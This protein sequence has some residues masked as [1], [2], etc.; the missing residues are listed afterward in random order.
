MKQSDTK[1]LVVALM[2]A[3][4]SSFTTLATAVA[5]PARLGPQDRST[6]RPPPQPNPC[7]NASTEPQLFAAEVV[8]PQALEPGGIA[9]FGWNPEYG[10]LNRGGIQYV[11]ANFVYVNLTTDKCTYVRSVNFGS[12]VLTPTDS[13]GFWYSLTNPPQPS[14]PTRLTHGVTVNFPYQQD[15]ASDMVSIVVGRTGGFGSVESRFPVVR[16][17][18]VEARDVL[19]SIGISRAELF[20][21]F[22]KALFAK[23]GPTNSTVIYD[24]DG[25]DWRIYGYDPRSLAVDITTAGVSFQFKFKLDIPFWCDP[26]VRAY[27]TFRLN[28]DLSGISVD[29]VH[30]AKGSATWPL[31]CEALQLPLIVPAIVGAVIGD[32]AESETSSSVRSDVEKAV[33]DAVPG[34]GNAT[35][36]LRGSA[37]VRDELLVNLSM[38]VPSVMIRPGYDAFDQ[39]RSGSLFAEGE[40]L[41]LVSSGLGMADYIAGSN[42]QTMLRSGPNGILLADTA[43]WP[44]PWTLARSGSLVWQGV[45]VGRLLVRTSDL[46]RTTTYQY[47]AGCS[48]P[49]TIRFGSGGGPVWVR[50]GVNDTAA[51]AQRLRSPFA[52]VFGAAPG[53]DVRVLFLNELGGT[54]QAPRCK[55]F[56]T[57]GSARDLS[58]SAR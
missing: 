39:S 10:R 20:N 43:T 49:V 6:L 1:R 53:Y 41:T 24:S 11:S 21:M 45:P 8:A 35:I 25:D 34:V 22:G 27:G 5:D 32:I 4:A 28:A 29:W 46:L 54:T 50:F 58:E 31:W 48:V 17:D 19:A 23:F 52:S 42:P 15:G 7:G 38:P 44:N 57:G 36:F 14:D 30:A 56:S 33:L 55:F 2:I 40:L 12:R 37:S 47:E 3:L 26:T 9:P 13:E 16:V 51:D 18:R